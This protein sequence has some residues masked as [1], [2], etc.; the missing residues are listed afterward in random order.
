MS[1]ECPKRSW[2]AELGASHPNSA[3]SPIR[4]QQVSKNWP[5]KGRS[6]QSRFGAA[7]VNIEPQ[8]ISLESASVCNRVAEFL[9]ALK[10]TYWAWDAFFLVVDSFW[11]S[12]VTVVEVFQD[13]VGEFVTAVFVNDALPIPIVLDAG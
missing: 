9:L 8:K 10:R 11:L 1:R 7:I 2:V 6:E 5:V 3:K 4:S 12:P 13:I